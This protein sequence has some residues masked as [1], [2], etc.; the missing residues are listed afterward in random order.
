MKKKLLVLLIASVL[1]SCSKDSESGPKGE[2]PQTNLSSEKDLISFTFDIE[3][4]IHEAEIKNDSI[5]AVLPSSVNLESLAPEIVISDKAKVSPASGVS[6]NFTNSINYTVT[7]EDSSTKSYRAYITKMN[8]ENS[9]ITFSFTNLANG[10]ASFKRINGNPSDIDTLLYSVPHLSPVEG[11]TSHIS[12]PENATIEPKSGETLDYS[13]PVE[14]AVT[15][16]DGSQKEYLIIVG[17]N[18]LGQVNIEGILGDGYRN[19]MP[20]EVISFTTNVL[21]PV[22]DSIKVKM[23]SP[24][25][26]ELEY[27]LE[28]QNI[29]YDNN[30]VSVVLP[31]SYANSHY[32]FKIFIEHDNFDESD[33]FILDSGTPNFINIKDAFISSNEYHVYST[34]LL[35]GERFS[36]S[37]YIN[38]QNFESHDFYLRKNNVDYPLLNPDLDNNFE[39]VRFY[40]PELPVSAPEGGTDFEFVIAYEGQ[41]Y[42][43]PILNSENNPIEILVAEPPVVNS[44]SSTTVVKGGGLTVFGENLYYPYQSG[45]NGI[46]SQKSIVKLKETTTG[47][48]LY[49]DVLNNDGSMT[50]TIPDDGRS[51]TYNVMF[52]SNINGFEEVNTG[53]TVTLELPESEH[54]TLEVTEALIHSTVSS[55]SKQI[56]IKFNGDISGVTINKIYLGTSYNNITIENYFTY[57][58]SVLTGS[59]SDEDHT[60]FYYGSNLHDGYVILEDGGVEYKLPFKLARGD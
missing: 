2:D 14:Y 44:L 9:I 19:K 30:E 11:L 38:R 45:D 41:E 3:G 60:N 1:F 20:N 47:V 29:N 4:E 5:V 24:L 53:F 26:P 34:L 39:L 37:T 48:S 42:T 57:P 16:E 28:I 52:N 55:F 23:L 56:Q 8:S 50:F 21:H 17:F 25:L 51:G 35:P 58:T 18:P 7:A 31:S 6:Q 59:L 32:Y 33:N 12:L 49:H 13:Q 22:Q 36:A 43:F 40:M 15:A 46:L 10:Q 54:S 27:E